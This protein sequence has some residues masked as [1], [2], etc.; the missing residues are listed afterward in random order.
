M[1][2]EYSNESPFA[3]GL[4]S[5]ITI[6]LFNI[7]TGTPACIAIVFDITS[8]PDVIL[9]INVLLPPITDIADSASIF[10][11]LPSISV[12]LDNS[13]DDI[14][15]SLVIECVLNPTPIYREYDFDSSNISIG[16]MCSSPF[17]YSV[18]KS[19]NIR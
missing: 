3:I 2:A 13:I 4:E 8:V 6:L 15:S 10:I 11:V 12:G 1:L 18:F 9:A 14:L 19:T 16:D 7:T 17:L 5:D